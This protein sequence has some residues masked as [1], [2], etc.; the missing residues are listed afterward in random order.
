[1][2]EYQLFIDGAWKKTASGELS[3]VLSPSTGEVVAKVQ[4]GSV[5][6]AN[7]ALEA[8]EK[9][10]KEWKKLPARTRAEYLYKLANEIKANSESLAGT[11]CKRTR[12]ITHSC[13]YGGGSYRFF[14][15][16]RL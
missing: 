12:K 6:D 9:A 11:T 4:N 14:Y 2:K 16:V 3:E 7:E 13:T 8:A 1:M 10:H 15:R 5:E